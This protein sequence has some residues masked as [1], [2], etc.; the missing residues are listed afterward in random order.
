MEQIIIEPSDT[1][2]VITKCTGKQEEGISNLSQF[3]EQSLSKVIDL[4]SKKMCDI[5][6]LNQCID[7]NYLDA[8]CA[9]LVILFFLSIWKPKFKIELFRHLKLQAFIVWLA[10]VAIYM[11]GFNEH[12]SAVSWIALT[13]RSCL[14]SMEMF[15][16]HSDL[17]E[18]RKE[19]HSN[20]TYMAIFSL[21]HFCA[22]AISAIFI[23]RLLGFRAVSWIKAAWSF[24]KSFIPLESCS[25]NYY[26]M[27]GINANTMAL[28][29]SISDKQRHRIIF[30]NIPDKGHSHASMRFSF[31]HFFHSN[32]NGV[33]KYI[34]DIERMGALLFNSSRSFDNADLSF[35]KSDVFKIFRALDFSWIGRAA[36]Q[37]SLRKTAMR[38]KG[39]KV[40]YFFLSENEQDNLIA[41]STLQKIQKQ[42]LNDECSFNCYCHARKNR[43][44][45]ALLNE[46]TLAFKVHIIDTSN[47]AMLELMTNSEHHPVNF[48]D[49]G[50]NPGTVASAFTGIIIGFGETGRDTFRFLYEFSS[51]TKDDEGNPSIKKIHVVD[52][53][54]EA[55]KADF[56][57]ETP[58]L[59]HKSEVD[60]WKVKSTH[61]EEFW[62]RLQEIIQELNYVVITVKNDEEAVDIATSIFEHAYRYR[63]NL[64][65]FKIFVRLRNS[66]QEDFLRT[67]REYF[68]VIIP[69]GSDKTAFSYEIINND[70]LEKRAKRFYY[71]YGVLRNDIVPSNYKD[72]ETGAVIEWIKR[73]KKYL[74]EKDIIKRKGLE[75]KMWYQEEQDRSNAW[76]IYTKVALAKDD[77]TSEIL[78]L[79]SS[80]SLLRN[81]C[82]CEHLRWN[83]KME[84]LGFEPATDMDIQKVEENRKDDKKLERPWKSFKLRKHECMVDCQT[85]HTHP[86][87][88]AT[89]PYDQST[90]ELSFMI[91]DI[92]KNEENKTQ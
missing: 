18:V 65:K 59:R 42:P 27:F 38:K 77:I 79:D 20:A 92:E 11:L 3:V 39:G 9:I 76:H 22:V 17:I 46:G 81:L 67:H 80:K 83:A 58:A 56:L 31:S 25:Y 34:E 6:C 21:V 54:I 16:S 5:D 82:D 52:K 86:I 13:L 4:C 63:D 44:N 75:I 64:N 61:S 50:K 15:V 49:K 7:I 71:K 37:K 78:L 84:L 2:Q 87:L 33:D 28:A 14:S 1:I 89:I 55:L 73:R 62:G 66:I 43:E 41:V 8:F 30:I 91:T 88:S 12:G 40:E 51:F 72:E 90:V 74:D 47:L 57:N 70:V 60:W 48:V 45:S 36:L 85:L 26:V 23:L 24:C 53:D 10:G 68:N 69:F 19:L 29:K 35:S 32:S